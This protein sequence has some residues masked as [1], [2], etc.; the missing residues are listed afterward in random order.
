MIGVELYHSV[1]RSVQLGDVTRKPRCSVVA[2]CS[3]SSS[4]VSDVISGTQ[5]IHQIHTR[6]QYT[7]SNTHK[8]LQA[9][10]TEQDSDP[11]QFSPIQMK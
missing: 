7:L 2:I 5:M 3:S 6:H 1:G 11:V 8:S 10:P 4:S 9:L